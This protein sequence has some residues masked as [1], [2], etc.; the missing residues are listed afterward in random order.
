MTSNATC[1][2]CG[3]TEPDCHDLQ[4]DGLWHCKC[5]KELRRIDEVLKDL[6]LQ[7]FY[8]RSNDVKT[9]SNKMQ[10]RTRVRK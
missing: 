9:V 4:R 1:T 6:G 3:E 8:N 5:K 10:K 7:L 2:K